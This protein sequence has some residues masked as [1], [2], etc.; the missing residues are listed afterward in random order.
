MSVSIVADKNNRTVIAEMGTIPNRLL[1]ALTLIFK[2]LVRDVATDATL[3]HRF[4]D[5][6]RNLGRSIQSGAAMVGDEIIGEVFGNDSIADYG[7]HVHDGHGSWRPDQFIEQ[8]FSRN[9]SEI[10]SA[11]EA[12]ISRELGL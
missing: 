3:H 9:E 11:I 10:T 5:R 2:K 1:P 4:T 7:I 12:T 6:T 8:A